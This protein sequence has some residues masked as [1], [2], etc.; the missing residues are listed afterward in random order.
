MF[1]SFLIIAVTLLLFYVFL[2]FL[3]ISTTVSQRHPVIFSCFA[4]ITCFFFRA[5]FLV[6]F[7]L[8]L[9][10]TLWCTNKSLSCAVTV[11][12]LTPF[13][14]FSAP[15]YYWPQRS[16]KLNGGC[17]HDHR[18]LELRHNDVIVTSLSGKWVEFE[19]TV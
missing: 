10:N 14:R 13:G 5:V 12:R 17:H 1:S 4:C 6:S 3:F 7:S 18:R 11:A 15:I 2:F 19:N 8:F 16:P 9:T